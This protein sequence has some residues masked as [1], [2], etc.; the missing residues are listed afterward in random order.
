M[1][2]V[3]E[4]GAAT[5]I[6]DADGGFVTLTPNYTEN[7][8]S[9]SLTCNFVVVDN[10]HRHAPTRIRVEFPQGTTVF[11]KTYAALA[12]PETVQVNHRTDNTAFVLSVS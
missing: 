4:D 3:T 10:S 1:A 8:N 9:G 7:T 2:I 6:N 5:R 12:A 11:D